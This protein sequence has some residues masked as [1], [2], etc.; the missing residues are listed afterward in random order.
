MGSACSTHL[1]DEERI[2]SFG[3]RAIIKEANVK[4]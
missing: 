4:T 2:E 1:R 3:V